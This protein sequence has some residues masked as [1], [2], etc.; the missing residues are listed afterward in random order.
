M[1]ES[2]TCAKFPDD[3]PKQSNAKGTITFATSG[4]NSR[5]TQVFVNFKDN[6]FLDGQGFA[7]FGKVTEGM[8]VVNAINAEY[9]ESPNQGLIQASGNSYLDGQFPKLD[10]I[11]S[12]KVL[13]Q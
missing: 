3:P 2:A 9:G 12:A 8:E 5:T 13:E 10:K 11:K 6:G 1:S 7:P 4:P